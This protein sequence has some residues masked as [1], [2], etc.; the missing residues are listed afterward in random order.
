MMSV[1]LLDTIQSIETPEGVELT[2]HVAGPVVRALAW[3]VDSFIRLGFYFLISQFIFNLGELG[4]G[5]FLLIIFLGEWFYHVLFEIYHQGATVGKWL[6][7]IKVLRDSGAPIGWSSSMIRNLLRVVD[8]LP[9]FNALGLISMI[10]S[11][12][13]QRL[14]DIAAQTIVVYKEVPI[15][16]LPLPDVPAC[17]LPYPLTLEEQ[18]ALISFA[19]RVQILSAARTAELA[20]II[21]PV[22]AERETTQM[23]YQFANG[24]VGVNKRYV[25]DKDDLN[26]N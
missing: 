2:L 5:F 20:N 7:G 4:I 3:L 6:F 8:F 13:F 14:G 17:D 10:I 26:Q 23:L 15:K 21:K 11:K 22:I 24:L 19:E 1:S 9:I 25:R 12:N 16:H 18:Q